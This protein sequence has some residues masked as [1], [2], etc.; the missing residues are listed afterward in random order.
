MKSFD[1]SAFFLKQIASD[2]DMSPAIAAMKALMESLRLDDST[3]LQEF[4]EK[5]KDAREALSK[6]DVSVVSVSSGCELFLRFITLS[7][8]ELE[9]AADF[10][11]CREILLRRGEDFI[12][13]MQ[14]SRRKIL[15]S[16]NNLI[17][18]GMVI[19]THSRSRNVLAVMT[20]AARQGRQFTVFVTESQP[21]CSGHR[22]ADD[23]RAVGIPCTVILDAA[24]G[25]IMERVS[26]VMVG[27]EG[28]CEN[29][30]ILNKIGS[31]TLATLAHMKNKPVYVLVESYKFIRTIPLNNSSLPKIYLH[32]ASVLNSGSDLIREHP[33]VDYTPPE[34]LTLLYTDLGV[35]P[36]SAITEHLIKLYT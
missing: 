21:D 2:D 30:G 25:Y 11:S 26:A 34:N 4:I 12:K 31:C 9:Q 7:H 19:L 35:L 22:V 1:I 29:G 16:S 27:A 8:K 6:T 18:D 5:M 32:R 10:A 17:K 20:E 13:S 28:V 23:L 3:T 14:E 15:R 33:L 24:V 36:T